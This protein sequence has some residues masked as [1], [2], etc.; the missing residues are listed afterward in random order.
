[1]F[2]GGGMR[3]AYQKTTDA[4]RKEAAVIS[5]LW[6]NKRLIDFVMLSSSVSEYRSGIRS[7]QSRSHPVHADMRCDGISPHQ[8][9]LIRLHCKHGGADQQCADLICMCNTIKSDFISQNVQKNP[10]EGRIT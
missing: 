5:L 1:M 6:E 4:G 2:T 10:P 3:A 7:R 8:S 9:G